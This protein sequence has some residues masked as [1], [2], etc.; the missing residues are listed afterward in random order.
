LNEENWEFETICQHTAEDYR[1][2]GAVVPPIFQNSLFVFETAD[3][4]VN[5][6]EDRRVWDYTRINNPTTDIAQRKIA[7]LEKA[8]SCRLFSSGMGAISAA[9]CSCTSAGSHVVCTDA[10]YGPTMQFLRDY[11][12]KFGVTTTFVD[13]RSTDAVR[14]AMRDNTSLIYLESPGTFYF[15]I[16]DIE[17]IATLAKESGAA[18]IL[19]NSNATPYFQNPIELGV[20]LVAHT[21]TKYLGGHSDIVIGVLCG[22]AARISKLTEEEGALFGANADPFA[23]WLMIRSLRTLAIRMERVQQSAL[24]IA[25]FLTGH[26]CVS[27]VYYPGLTSHPGQDLIR[28]QMRGTSGLMSFEPTFQTKESAYRFCERLT[29]FQMGVSWGGHESLAIPLCD[30]GR[31]DTWFVRLSVGLESADD[32]ISDLDSCLRAAAG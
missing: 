4:F 22:S 24:A 18:T 25:E 10:A 32:L 3:A 26:P 9:I 1:F 14:D 29:L 2:E 21:G 8:E 12:P 11:L 23:S 6:V 31:N 17:A 28:K 16:Q 20:D 19:D 5:R 7:A 30:P 15:H 27:H 13:G